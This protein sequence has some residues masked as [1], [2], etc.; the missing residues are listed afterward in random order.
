MGRGD[1]PALVRMSRTR[2]LK[3]TSS[4]ARARGRPKRL[5]WA[6]AHGIDSLI[7]RF[8]GQKE[9]VMKASTGSARLDDAAGRQQCSLP[10]RERWCSILMLV[11]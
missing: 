10:P 5:L 9:V 7:R 8:P 11:V 2:Q 6:C 3:P 4:C 1:C